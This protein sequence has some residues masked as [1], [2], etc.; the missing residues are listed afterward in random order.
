MPPELLHTSLL[1]L[2]G[3]LGLAGIAGCVFP[4][5]GHLCLLAAAG[6]VSYA[7]PGREDALWVWVAL[8]ILTIVGVLVDN[9]TSYFGAKKFGASKAALYCCLVGIFVGSFFFPL[10]LILGPLIG[11]FVGEFLITKRGVK[12]ASKSAIGGLL[13]YLIGVMSKLFIAGIMLVLIL[14][15]GGYY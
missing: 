6:C 5:P 4:Y 13:G 1:V 11:A 2:A 7:N 10:G 14:A 9:V 15:L 12:Q 8:S 3:L